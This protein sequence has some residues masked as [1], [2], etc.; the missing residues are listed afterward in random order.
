MKKNTLLVLLLFFCIQSNAQLT[1][2]PDNNFETYLE[3]HDAN[4][5]TVSVGD[6]TSMGNGIA[7]DDYALTNRIDTVTD[8]SLY[9]QAIADF[10]GLENFTNLEDFVTTDATATSLDFT[11]NTKLDRIRCSY[12]ANLTSVDITGL[13]LL[14]H[15]YLY[16]TDLSVVDVST[17]TALTELTVSYSNLISIDVSAN[18]LLENLQLHESSISAIDLSANTN[19]DTLIVSVSLFTELNLTNN[20]LL[21]YLNCGRN[22]I[23]AIS[24]SHLTNLESLIIDETNISALDLSSN[25]SLMLLSAE[26]LP[27]LNSLNVKNGNNSNVTEFEATNNPNLT[28]I[29]VDDASAGYLSTWVKDATAS[30]NETCLETYVPDDIFENYLETHDANGSTVSV[31]DIT[32]MGNGIANDDYVFTNRVDTVL[33][34]SLYSLAIADFTGLEDF[35][36]LED[37]RTS[38]AT[39]TNLDFTNNIKLDRISCSYMANLTSVDITGLTL[40]DFLYL[41]QTDLSVVDVSTNIAL[42]DLII[43]YSNLTSIDVSTNVLLEDLQLHE[44]SI[45]A[46]DLSTNTLLDN[47]TVSVSLFTA[48]DLTNNVLLERINCGRNPLTT[49]N[50]SHLTN[51]EE[52]TVDENLF[53]SL[54]LS[55]NVNLTIFSAEDLPNLNYLNFRNGNNSNVTEFEVTNN[56]N[57]TCIEVDDPTA[58]YLNTWVKDA[59]ASYAQFCRLTYVP[60]DNF[61]NYLETHD[62]SGN[63]VSV[64]DA[65]S[66]GNGIANDDYVFTEAIELVTNLNVSY[67]TIA[68]LTGIEDFTVLEE[69]RCYENN[70][71][72]LSLT[73]NTALIV[74]RCRENGMTSLDVSQNVNLVDLYCQ[75][76]SLTSLDVTQ[77]TA[78]VKLSFYNNSLTNIDVTQN[79]LLEQIDCVN[80][81]LTSIDVSACPQLKYFYCDENNLTSLDVSQNTLL[82]EFYCGYNQ[83]VSLDVSNCTVL[84][85][86]VCYN[87]SLNSLN[88]KNGNNAAIGT[89]EIQGNANLICV[90]VDNASYSNTNWISKDAQTNY[91]ETDCNA[92]VNPLVFLQGAALNPNIGEETLMRDDLRVAGLIPTTS[93][94]G[95]GTTCDIT[96]FD[97]TGSNAIVDWVWVEL[98]D[99]TDNTVVIE[100]QAALVTRNGLLVGV[101]GT[102]GLSFSSWATKYHVAI[103]HRNHLGI[104][105]S[106]SLVLNHILTPLDFSN[107]SITTYGINGQTTSGMPSG[108]VAMWSGDSSGDGRLSYSG[109]VSDTPLIRSQVFNDPNNSFLGGPPVASYPSQ[110]YY[111]TDINMDGLTIYSG[112]ESDVLRIRNNIFNNSSNSFLGG[113]PTSTYIFTQQL[114]EGAN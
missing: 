48:L 51:L 44:S 25:T 81:N 14:D 30:F 88:I 75:K 31:G 89:I 73:K 53:A 77:N 109:G 8:L 55:S 80:N 114:P 57:L 101:T 69:L 94:Y 90:L 33:D 111:K 19:L 105:T 6:A 38:D 12:M 27:N 4:G 1:Y 47:L 37:F 23:G 108:V 68:N 64:G 15:L 54:D 63:T 113:P 20:V 110:G 7:N 46:I 32:S 42:T 3:T 100:S 29:K 40:L 83:I 87:N 50:L 21:K 102:P 67:L 26:D 22:P 76:N 107:G 11:N 98:R 2:V 91:S 92:K 112:A 97:T 95:D 17:N 45:S 96:L 28:C 61:E 85:E 70:I 43:S 79:I 106:T 104:M 9:N 78:L 5:S 66:M 13:T 39:A 36:N 41:Y 99:A 59:T 82:D 65:S 16:Q 18:V 103:K 93:P 84:D 71:T 62:A 49:V 34:L 86:F 35:I 56:P 10:T 74:L 52:L 24:I 72:T 60:D 58:T